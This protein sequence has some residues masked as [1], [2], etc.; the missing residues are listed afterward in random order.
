MA[1][2]KKKNP[3]GS[4][5]PFAKAMGK[6]QEAFDEQK[7]VKGGSD[8]AELAKLLKLVKK[9]QSTLAT[10]K[11]AKSECGETD[12]GEPFV[13]H[14]FTITRGDAEGH[15]V[16][17]YSVVKDY[18]EKYK[19]PDVIRNI[20]QE[21]QALGYET[22]DVTASDLEEMCA[23]LC[24]TT[25]EVQIK[26]KWSG[27]YINASIKK[28]LSEE[29]SEDEEEEESSDEEEESSEDDEESSE[30]E[31]ESSEDEEGDAA[32]EKGDVVT[33]D[34]DK[35]KVQYVVKLV[36]EK[37]QTVDLVDVKTKKTEK[38]A[39]AWTEISFVTED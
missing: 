33:L 28:V 16:T 9:G 13:R 4:S 37:K 21:F 29:S 35:K 23:D 34:N 18:S 12:Q 15:Q 27:E 22:E 26:L 3:K 39:V 11:L 7:K 14:T 8:H 24:S 2:Q 5:N 10:A 1:F 30:D 38:K 6:Y 31:E 36:N 20:C 19:A 32:P 25:P 17:S